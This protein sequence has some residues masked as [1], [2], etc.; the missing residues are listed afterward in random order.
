[1]QKCF[2]FLIV[3]TFRVSI[4][5]ST[6]HSQCIISKV[7]VDGKLC[8]F[9]FKWLLSH[10]QIHSSGIR[11]RGVWVFEALRLAM[12][13]PTIWGPT[14]QKNGTWGIIIIEPW[15]HQAIPH[16]PT[17]SLNTRAHF[18]LRDLNFLILLPYTT[19]WSTLTCASFLW[20]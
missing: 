5:R 16:K 7:S 20:S 19:N 1:M 6:R 9:L 2:Q 18:D 4:S 10:R 12:K 11:Q 3:S 13:C 15:F 17:K 8:N 14:A